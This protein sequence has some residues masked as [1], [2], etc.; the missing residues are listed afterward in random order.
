MTLSAQS[1]IGVSLPML[2]QPY[3][4]YAEFAAL[5]EAAGFDSDNIAVSAGVD[6]RIGEHALAEQPLL[7]PPARVSLN[8]ESHGD[9][10]I[11]AIPLPQ[12]A[13]SNFGF[14]WY[15]L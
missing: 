6:Q 10:T 4:R 3:E 9:R 11:S 12:I 8:R 14:A 7:L 2:N 5:A 1:R 13:A 15:S